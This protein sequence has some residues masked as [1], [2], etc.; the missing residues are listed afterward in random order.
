MFGE[1]KENHGKA[2]EHIPF[3]PLE[4][5]EDI[6]LS[7][8]IYTFISKEKDSHEEEEKPLNESTM[9]QHDS[10]EENEDE[11]VAQI[12]FINGKKDTLSDYNIIATDSSPI[13]FNHVNHPSHYN[14]NEI[15]TMEM[16][17][18]MFHGK[19]EYIK[20]ALLFNIFKYRDR[21]GKKDSPGDREKMLWYLDKFELLFPD[22]FE[23]YSIYHS[24]KN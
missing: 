19:P 23:L 5:E 24:T 3:R 1:Y 10:E 2:K 4:L 8:D 7:E 15:E 21:L 16:I 6:V 9:V 22:D 13:Q 20:G 12:T 14:S 11:V 18:L 17:L